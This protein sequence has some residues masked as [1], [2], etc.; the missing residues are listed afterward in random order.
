[1]SSCCTLF[2][3]VAG[4]WVVMGISHGMFINDF[5]VSG[6]SVRSRGFIKTESEVKE[7]ILKVHIPAKF[8]TTSMYGFIKKIIATNRCPSSQY[9]EICFGELSHIDASGVTVLSNIIEWLTKRGVVT[10]LLVPN[11]YTAPIVYLDDS[12]FFKYHGSGAPLRESAVLRKTTAPLQQICHRDSFSWL[13]NDFTLWMSDN[14]GLDRDHFDD[15][16]TCLKE[17][18]LNIN[19]HSG[20]DIGCVFMQHRRRKGKILIS[21]SDFGVGIPCMVKRGMPH[22][23]DSDAILK[24]CEKDFSTMST[25]RN[26]GA[27]LPH[28]INHI[29]THHSG[30]IAIHSNCGVARFRPQAGPSG[31]VVSSFYPGTLFEVVLST[32][33][34]FIRNLKEE[35]TW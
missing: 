20:E 15:I 3:R 31:Q 34:K 14:L 1:M 22:L 28:P 25:P 17:I 30:T 23:D 8:N 2:G 24:A 7:D 6:G 12:G 11:I 35:F 9:I 21:L 4:V 10:R 18:F 19:D 33:D 27:G 13:D 5:G 26:R 29:V 16:K 32:D